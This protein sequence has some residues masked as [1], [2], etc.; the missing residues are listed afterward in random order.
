MTRHRWGAVPP[1]DDLGAVVHGPALLGRGE[2]IAAGLRCVYAYPTGLSLPFVVRARGLAADVVAR[3]SSETLA[4]DPVFPADHEPWSGVRFAVQ[5]G[6]LTGPADPVGLRGQGGLEDFDADGLLWVGE[7]PAD[8]LVRITVSWAEA[9]LP[10]S[11]TDL[12]L[13]D[14]SDLPGRV[15]TL[16]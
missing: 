11:T 1:P 7:L 4:E 3:W 9:G 13:G 15:V 2:R 6:D 5:V 10:V 12:R 8:G 14:L 16:T